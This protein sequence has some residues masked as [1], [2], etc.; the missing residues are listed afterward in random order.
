[1]WRMD[2]VGLVSF[3]RGFQTEL[4]VT[5]DWVVHE[6]DG[7]RQLAVVKHFLMDVTDECVT[8]VLKTKLTLKNGELLYSR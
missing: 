5:G 1:M 8:L 6:D 2:E 7:R 3:G 4:A